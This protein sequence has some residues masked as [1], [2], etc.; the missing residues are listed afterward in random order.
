MSSDIVITIQK[1][2]PESGRSWLDS[3]KWKIPN[4][5]FAKSAKSSKSQPN[6]DCLY[7]LHPNSDWSVVHIVG[8]R[9]TITLI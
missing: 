6:F 1:F 7:L 3:V 9:A 8:I 2:C 4:Y 5:V